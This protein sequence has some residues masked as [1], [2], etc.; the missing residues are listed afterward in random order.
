MVFGNRW[1]AASGRTLRTGMPPMNTMIYMVVAS[2]LAATGMALWFSA[3]DLTNGII[4]GALVWLYFVVPVS[5][6]AIFYEGRSWMW[7]VITA[8]YW[9]VGL[10]LMGAIV[11]YL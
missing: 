6:A 9:L 4:S 2:L 10:M 11:S 1:A 5:A 8:G 3:G 7:W